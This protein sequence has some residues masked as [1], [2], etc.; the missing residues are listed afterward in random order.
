MMLCSNHQVLN[1]VL[2]KQRLDWAFCTE[3]G[4]G[5]QHVAMAMKV[6]KLFQKQ[7]CGLDFMGPSGYMNEHCCVYN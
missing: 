3:R 2:T 5:G 4:F 6:H 1:V 7:F